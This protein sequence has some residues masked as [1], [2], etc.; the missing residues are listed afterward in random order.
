MSKFLLIC[1]AAILACLIAQIHSLPTSDVDVDKRFYG[2]KGGEK[3]YNLSL[4]KKKWEKNFPGT[5][6]KWKAEC[7]KVQHRREWRSLTKKEQKKYTDAIRCMFNKKSITTQNAPGARHRF[8]DFCGV[9]I[10]QTD[11]IHFVGHFLPWHRLMMSVYEEYL[12]AECG[13]DGAIPYWDWSLDSGVDKFPKS[14]VFAPSAFGG[15]GDFVDVDPSNTTGVFFPGRTGGGC[16]KNGAFVGLKVNVGPGNSTAYN[17]H[18]I[19]RDFVPD[20]SEVLSKENVEKT[21]GKP[22]FYNFDFYFQGEDFF[23]SNFNMSE[24][25]VH[26]AGHF[27]IG[28]TLGS[29]GSQYS[30]CSDP[31][32]YLH[33]AQVDRLWWLWQQKNPKKR[34]Y[35]IGGPVDPVPIFGPVPISPKNVTLDFPI[36]LAELTA[37]WKIT[38]RD[39]MD[40]VSGP[41]CYDYI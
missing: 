22:D 20:L 28:G 27:V 2:P 19:S 32:F 39:M 14:P 37:P 11:H 15:N 29:M 16:V 23:R 12:H 25:G 24:F 4:K 6:Y 40:T 38:V 1:V 34:L 10:R 21:L 36:D 17:P 35:E 3:E 8:D 9:H 5:N 33:H 18:C 26:G 30:S 13:Y 41:L 31:T 7:K